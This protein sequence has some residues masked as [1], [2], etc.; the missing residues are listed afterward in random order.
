MSEH[1]SF[2]SDLMWNVVQSDLSSNDFNLQTSLNGGT[3]PVW[4]EQG[5]FVFDPSD[6]L[7][8]NLIDIG[9]ILKLANLELVN[10]NMMKIENLEEIWKFTSELIWNFH[11]N[12]EKSFLKA[13]FGVW[14]NVEK[15]LQN[16]KW[17][18]SKEFTLDGVEK[19][20]CC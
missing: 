17:T 20:N 18:F 8:I 5:V 19:F 4:C 9:D 16:F 14:Q 11:T 2:P 1:G 7:E 13:N 6:L 15:T 12:D 10:L 3:S